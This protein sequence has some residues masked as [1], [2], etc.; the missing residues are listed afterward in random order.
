MLVLWILTYKVCD[1][2]VSFCFTSC[3]YLRFNGFPIRDYA[4]SMNCS[5]GIKI[6]TACMLEVLHTVSDIA[7]VVYYIEYYVA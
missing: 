4:P 5:S 6:C 2:V 1:V 7:L 3:R